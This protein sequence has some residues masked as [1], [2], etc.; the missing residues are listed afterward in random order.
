MKME[1]EADDACNKSL[2]HPAETHTVSPRGWRQIYA[3]KLLLL[4]VTA[5]HNA[6][7]CR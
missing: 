7:M 1:G 4:S 2:I 6:T 3:G 5:R